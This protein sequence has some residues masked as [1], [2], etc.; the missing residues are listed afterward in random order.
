MFFVNQW[1]SNYFSMLIH[2]NTLLFVALRL[3]SCSYLNDSSNTIHQ[4]DNPDKIIDAFSPCFLSDSK[5]ILN[6]SIHI[7][8]EQYSFA[9]VLSRWPKFLIENYHTHS[10]RSLKRQWPS[11]SD[12]DKI[13]E[14][15]LLLI[16]DSITD[17]WK[18]N[19][20]LI[21]ETLF[22]LMNELTL[23]F[24]ILCQQLFSLTSSTRIIIKHCFLNYC[25]KYGLL[26]TK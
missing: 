2:S 4:N 19:F 5:Y 21:E 13:L 15:S 12:L 3:P 1:E 14:Q 11:K 26:L 22:R 10:D 18:L 6:D 24:Y 25:E 7:D 8:Y 9:F 17:K 16:P 20:D 23:F